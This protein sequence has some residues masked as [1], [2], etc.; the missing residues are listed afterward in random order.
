MRQTQS[1]LGVL[2][3]LG[4]AAAT[5]VVGIGGCAAPQRPY[6]FSAPQMAR[7]PIEALNSAMTQVGLTPIVTDP[8]RGVAQTRWEDTGQK[9][10]LLKEHEAT[11]VRR[12]TAT[13][14]KGA[15][16]SDVTLSE[17]LQRCSVGRFT[18]LETDVQGECQVLE[19][20]PDKHQEELQKLGAR[21]QQAMQVP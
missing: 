19:R 11:Y 1:R 2:G 15:F 16:G 5:A 9:A 12:Y 17:S 10:G 6:S 20:L 18:L 8:Q 7:D 13:L 3:V 14:V 4:V 21:L